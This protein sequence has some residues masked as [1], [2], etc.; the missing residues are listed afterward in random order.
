M[1]SDWFWE[2][3][4]QEALAVHLR[5]EGWDVRQL[6]DTASRARGID[7]LATKDE[8]TLAVEVKGYPSTT[9]ARGALQGMPKRTN[10]TN[11]APKW[12]SQALVKAIA[13]TDGGGDPEVA[14]AFPDHAR[15]RSLIER[16]E[17]AL[18]RLR[19]GVYLV[20][21]DGTVE[22]LLDHKPSD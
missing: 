2:G 5:S 14:I 1:S 6:A 22:L 11:Q 16:S 17:W 7:V 13:T 9:Y 8:R 4:V 12:F 21:D 18:A 20:K 10:P 19:V 15:F 3:N